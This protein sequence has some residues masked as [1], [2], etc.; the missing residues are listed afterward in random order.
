MNQSNFSSPL[1]LYDHEEEVLA[2]DARGNLVASVDSEGNVIVRDMRSPEDKVAHIEVDLGGA[3][4]ETGALKFNNH[5]S[6]ELFI[7]V[8]R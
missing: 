7:A 5:S 2:G 1:I 4:Y 8:N 6:D 3:Q